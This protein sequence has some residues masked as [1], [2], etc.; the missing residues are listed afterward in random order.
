MTD[1]AAASAEDAHRHLLRIDLLPG[2]S[3][4]LSPRPRGLPP[5]EE[6]WAWSDPDAPVP[7]ELLRRLRHAGAISALVTESEARRARLVPLD[8]RAGRLLV[9][10]TEPHDIARLAALWKQT[11][12]KIA[13]VPVREAD[14]EELLA[15]AYSPRC[16]LQALCIQASRGVPRTSVL[17]LLVQWSIRA[18]GAELCAEGTDQ[19]MQIR[20]RHADRLVLVATGPRH[21]LSGLLQEVRDR[22][23]EPYGPFELDVP[24]HTARALVQVCPTHHGGRVEISAGADA[25]PPLAALG[26]HRDNVSALER[27]LAGSS[28]LIA[29]L[30]GPRSGRTTTGLALVRAATGGDATERLAISVE[31]SIRRPVAGVHQLC[32]IPR[33]GLTTARTLERALAQRPDAVLVDAPL[34]AET[35]ELAVGA[36][37]SGVRVVLCLTARSFEG[38]FQELQ[39][40][41]GP[42]RDPSEWLGLLVRQ[43]LLPRV[44]PDCRIPRS[45]RLPWY[46]RRFL[47][48]ED[49]ARMTVAGA[50]GALACTYRGEGCETCSHSGQPGE[51]GCIP[52]E[53][54][55]AVG[56][57]TWAALGSGC[58][59]RELNAL[60]R[61]EEQL[62]LVDA[63]KA[64]VADGLVAFEHLAELFR[65]FGSAREDRSPEPRAVDIPGPGPIRAPA[66]CRQLAAEFIQRH[67][68]APAI[69]LLKDA[70][71]V[72]P[73]MDV[74]LALLLLY[75]TALV[76]EGHPE[77]GGETLREVAST[78]RERLERDRS[79][80]NLLELGVL[81]A[82]RLDGAKSADENLAAAI[83]HLAEALAREPRSVVAL[84]YLARCRARAGQRPEAR[85]LL[86]RILAREP[87]N[88]EA[89]RHLG[90]LALA[91]GDLIAVVA[92]L[93]KMI[94]LEPEDVLA[95]MQLIDLYA[96]LCRKHP[97]A[98]HRMDA[99]IRH[100]E[101]QVRAD[102]QNAL[103]HFDL[104]Y[105]YLTLSADL[106]VD[107]TRLSQATFEFKVTVSLNPASPA[108]YWGLR[109]V[110]AAQSILGRHAYDLAIQVCLD[111]VRRNPTLARA[112]FELGEAYH[113]HHDRDLKS[114]ALTAYE[115]A[116]ELDPALIE[117]RERVASIHRYRN[118]H[119]E[120]TRAYHR[121]IATDPWS[122]A[123]RKA[124]R[125]LGHA[126]GAGV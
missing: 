30:G 119:A 59:R 90:E 11:G 4:G 95:R 120:A 101:K 99:L 58:T 65:P 107:E 43:R 89:H 126:Q 108:G 102:F 67:E 110:H 106:P 79:T 25:P 12:F 17:R 24:P 73:G 69:A 62:R 51:L 21:L 13:A 105:A 49:L 42:R 19:G 29:V 111:A 56:S 91:E 40:L 112:Q 28:R 84:L 53:E 87:D 113:E 68:F 64:K 3:P 39:E 118:E 124:R 103:A 34:D 35:L 75:H 63:A 86:R 66:H 60:A 96:T 61:S 72:A 97:D 48:D 92:S 76:I 117:A 8:V 104:G 122:R 26:F 14:I 80:E 71:A 47:S 27:Q 52:V 98:G 23:P 31:A 32:T 125:M 100:F 85:D 115:R 121:V 6:L 45:T 57:R 7:M 82:L 78:C 33:E 93:Q 123:A 54:L 10:L 77:V 5:I 46:H 36:S 44:C 37:R 81:H 15:R 41:T 114:E 38:A 70:L 94:A 55:L 109:R 20:V 1:T 88:R 83:D 22:A 16:Q 18:R 50:K 74:R 2:G 9:A 116:L